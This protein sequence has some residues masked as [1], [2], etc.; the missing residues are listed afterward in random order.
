MGRAGVAADAGGDGVRTG[1]RARVHRARM[2]QA[3][4]VDLR[5]RQGCGFPEVRSLRSRGTNFA[6]DP[7]VRTF[8]R[9]SAS[10]RANSRSVTPNM[11]I[12]RRSSKETGPSPH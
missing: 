8:S 6:A 7:K 2:V 1:N 9:R 11:E 4:G 10:W 5:Y 3:A 12:D